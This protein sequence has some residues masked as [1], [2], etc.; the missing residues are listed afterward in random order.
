MTDPYDLTVFHGMVPKGTPTVG[1]VG[2]PKR[3]RPTKASPERIAEIRAKK[4]RECRLCGTAEHVNAH[5]LIPRGMG[6]TIGGEWTESN[7]VGLCG[8]GNTDGC[9]GLVE[10]RDRAALYLLRASLTDAE[11]S[12]VETKMG[13]GWLSR[14]YP[15]LPDEGAAA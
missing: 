3:K 5:H 8:H 11:Y 1:G 12:Y 14:K 9:H 13:E 6:G 7:I 15:A 4:C 2:R 10:S